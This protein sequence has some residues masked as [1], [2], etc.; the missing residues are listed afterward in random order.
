MEAK[1]PG[2]KVGVEA[3]QFGIV[4]APFLEEARHSARLGL[5]FARKL[6]QRGLHDAARRAFEPVPV[7]PFHK[8]DFTRSARGRQPGLMR[9]SPSR[10]I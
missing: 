7:R 1:T 10:T 6:R 3:E 2:R 5:E 4:L 9:L 8:R